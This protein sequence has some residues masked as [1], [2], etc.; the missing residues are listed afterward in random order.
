VRLGRPVRV[1][2]DGRTA[3]GKTTLADELA[4]LLRCARSEFYRDA[5]ACSIGA[6]RRSTISYGIFDMQALIETAARS[7]RITGSH[8]CLGD[9]AASSVRSAEPRDRDDLKAP[10]RCF[11]LVEATDTAALG[12][13]LLDDALSSAGAAGS[14]SRGVL[15]RSRNARCHSE[16]GFNSRER[17]N[18]GQFCSVCFSSFPEVPPIK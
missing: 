10:P 13:V 16:N 11:A 5:S 17:T 9:D 14:I 6:E 1:A 12:G 4:M 18:N 15:C 7:P 3:S 8:L 2:I